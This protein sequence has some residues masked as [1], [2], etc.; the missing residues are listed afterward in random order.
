M[1]AI[2]N[3]RVIVGCG[4]DAYCPVLSARSIR[5]G[6]VG[7]QVNRYTARLLVEDAIMIIARFELI[8]AGSTAINKPMKKSGPEEKNMAAR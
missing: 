1:L 6:R 2:E 8:P 7:V 4:S 5:D 3:C